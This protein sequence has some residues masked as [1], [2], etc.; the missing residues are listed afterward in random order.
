MKSNPEEEL[1]KLT[2]S[3]IYVIRGVS[4]GP[5]IGVLNTIIQNEVNYQHNKVEDY[6]PGSLMQRM[7]MASGNEEVFIKTLPERE[8]ELC[9]IIPDEM[10]KN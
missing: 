9:L 2:G 10:D 4:S 5:I 6:E 1:E 7:L 8:V 3:K